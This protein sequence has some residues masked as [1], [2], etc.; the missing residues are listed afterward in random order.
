MTALSFLAH[1]L[2]QTALQ[3]N[4]HRPIPGVFL[5]SVEKQLSLRPESGSRGGGTFHNI[6]WDNFF[7]NETIAP[8]KNFVLVTDELVIVVLMSMIGEVLLPHR[9]TRK[10]HSY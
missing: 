10:L 3:R 8:E 2:N 9:S 7:R 5:P 4:L 6:Q 1:P